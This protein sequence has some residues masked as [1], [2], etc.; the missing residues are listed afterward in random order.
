MSVC[1][2]QSHFTCVLRPDICELE[3][4]KD[5]R[6]SHVPYL[7]M[8]VHRMDDVGCE[9]RLLRWPIGH[10]NARQHYLNGNRFDITIRLKL[11]RH[12]N[13][14]RK[15]YK[16][17]RDVYEFPDSISCYRLTNGNNNEYFHNS[18]RVEMM[19]ICGRVS[20]SSAS[21]LINENDCYALHMIHTN[22]A[23]KVQNRYIQF[24]QSV[25][26]E[27]VSI[28]SMLI[29]FLTKSVNFHSATTIVILYR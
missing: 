21:P 20:D 24:T 22:R 4:K 10:R 29:V 17:L 27:L 28:G 11:V 7:L 16:L 9:F 3:R 26:I 23:T 15:W 5:S 6:T 25:Q 12:S 18:Y 1:V 2:W 19:N 8:N 13:S 14:H